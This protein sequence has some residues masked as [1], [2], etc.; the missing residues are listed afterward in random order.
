MRRGS[1]G[2]KGCCAQLGISWADTYI[3]PVFWFGFPAILKGWVE[4]VFALGDAYTFAPEG[5]Q[6]QVKGRAP[7]LHHNHEYNHVQRSRL[8]GGL[9]SANDGLI[10]ALQVRHQKRKDDIDKHSKVPK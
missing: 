10:H 8:C 1:L 4:R 3:S 5:W 7:L 2:V 6:G 9:A